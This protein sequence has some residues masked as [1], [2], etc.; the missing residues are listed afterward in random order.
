L[1]SENFL[2]YGGFAV[3]DDSGDVSGKNITPHD[4]GMTQFEKGVSSE[5]VDQIP[6][7]EKAIGRRM[8]QT[9]EA[10]WV[11]NCNVVDFGVVAQQS[12]KQAQPPKKSSFSVELP[13][14]SVL[15]ELPKRKES[16]WAKKSPHGR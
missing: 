14:T 3:G 16:R 4:S 13:S 7:I 6:M 9:E 5:C 8:T 2:G 1:N 12:K 15:V 10:V 11:R